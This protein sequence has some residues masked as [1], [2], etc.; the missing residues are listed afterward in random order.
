[1]FIDFR[2]FNCSFGS[3]TEH[4]SQK[5]I[6]GDIKPSS[7]CINKIGDNVKKMFCTAID[8]VRHPCCL[9]YHWN[10]FTDKVVEEAEPAVKTSTNIYVTASLF[11]SRK[12][13]FLWYSEITMGKVSLWFCWQEIESQGTQEMS[14]RGLWLRPAASC[15][16][17]NTPWP[18]GC[19]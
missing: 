13:Q 16:F 5:M 9:V 14:W 4:A 7:R 11:A 19:E 2:I 10:I 12:R 8:T 6:L 1:M 18:G 3:D 17:I 15:V